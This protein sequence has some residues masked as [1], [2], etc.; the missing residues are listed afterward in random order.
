MDALKWT[1]IRCWP[2]GPAC[3]VNW[4]AWAAIGTLSAVV[5]ALAFGFLSQ[6]AAVR[7]ARG[8]RAVAIHIARA[9][10]KTLFDNIETLAANPGVAGNFWDQRIVG[11]VLHCAAT[12]AGTCAELEK[13]MLDLDERRIELLAPLVSECRTIANEIY[14]LSRHDSLTQVGLADYSTRDTHRRALKVLD[15]EVEV[16]TVLDGTATP[17]RMRLPRSPRVGE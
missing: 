2:L 15:Q 1:F 8:R 5:V 7:V 13:F 9:Q 17:N 16:M 6:R 3:E 14:D 12:V 4:D 10:A 11:L